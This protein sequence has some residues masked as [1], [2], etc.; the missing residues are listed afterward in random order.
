MNRASSILFLSTLFGVVL[1]LF[2]FQPVVGAGQDLVRVYCVEGSI[3]GF[4]G[5]GVADSTKDLTKALRGKDK[6]LFVV[7]SESDADVVVMVTGREVVRA[8]DRR[9]QSYTTTDKK[10]NVSTSTYA[11]QDYVNVVYATLQ[12]GNFQLDLEGANGLSWRGA[13]GSVAGQV[14]RWVK[15]NRSRIFQLA[16]A[17]MDAPAGAD[18]S[19]NS[20]TH[21]DPEPPPVD[22]TIE[23]GMT[24]DQV[25][26]SLGEPFRK[27]TF[28]AKTLWTYDG[29]QVVFENGGVVDVKF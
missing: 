13:A 28:G 23:L 16:A 19:F 18:P 1:V 2:L 5:P 10:G 24:P 11:S 20:D 25:L 29:L 4:V 7:D 14:D 6:T 27:V 3:D 21:T 15:E 12:A 17:P 9:Y 22:A 26:Q 8:G